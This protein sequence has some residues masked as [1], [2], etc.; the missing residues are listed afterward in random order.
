MT[1][2]HA[3]AAHLRLTV[4]RNGCGHQSEPDVAT[5][6]ARQGSGIPVPDWARLLRCTECGERDAEFHDADLDPA[7]VSQPAAYVIGSRTGSPLATAGLFFDTGSFCSI[8]RIKR[9]R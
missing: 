2:G 6:V 1:L 4:W 3:L 7:Q 5:Q 8:P 9:R